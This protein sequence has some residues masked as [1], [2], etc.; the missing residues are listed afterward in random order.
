MDNTEKFSGKAEIYAKFRP[1][2]PSE[3]IKMLSGFITPKSVVADIGA[4]TGLFTKC[5][6]L[7]G[8]DIIAVEPNKDMLTQAT[9]A[10][11]NYE[12]VTFVK[13]PAEDTMLAPNSIDLITV[14]QAFH[15]F[16]TKKFKEECKRILKAD[17]KVLLVWNSLVYDNPIIKELEVINQEYCEEYYAVKSLK[18]GTDGFSDFFE[19][20]DT[21][22][23]ENNLCFDKDGFIGNRLSR[24]Y[25]PKKD[26]KQYNDYIHE[27]EIFFEKHIK[28]DKIIIPNITE[29]Y[30]GNL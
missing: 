14:A 13:S 7:L 24:S 5:L 9:K 10:L 23:Y 11:T 1:S 26:D 16:D 2:Y 3:L 21:F 15:W 8:C 6:C 30:L 4:G 12:K 28:N 17:G 18:I 22:I 27:L 25:A 29:C 19:N 20:F